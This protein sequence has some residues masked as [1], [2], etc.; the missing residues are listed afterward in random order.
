MDIQ[1]KNIDWFKILVFI[2]VAL[3][4]VTS[5]PAESEAKPSDRGLFPYYI[6]IGNAN[7]PHYVYIT[8]QQEQAIHNGMKLIYSIDLLMSLKCKQKILN[9][10]IKCHLFIQ[11]TPI[12]VMI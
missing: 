1:L 6:N 2:S 11:I 3:Q 5:A 9:Y 4:L 12:L 10:L 7:D 8:D